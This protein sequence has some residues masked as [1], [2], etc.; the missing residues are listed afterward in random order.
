MTREDVEPDAPDMHGRWCPGCRRAIGPH[1]Y[2][3]GMCWRLLPKAL[4]TRISETWAGRRY[5]P[6][7]VAR[8][9]HEEAKA[10][11]DAWLR[12]HYGRQS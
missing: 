1:L 2:A 8:Q 12:D 4:R 3:C 7:S 11:G 10:A 6:N 9:R 5:V